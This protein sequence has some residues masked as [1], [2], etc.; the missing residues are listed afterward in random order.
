[1]TKTLPDL[2]SDLIS[3]ALNDLEC[4]ELDPRY[5]IRM[6]QWH[7]PDRAT[8]TCGVCFAG[9]VIAFS[10]DIPHT[11]THGPSRFNDMKI[12]NKL[13][14]LDAFRQGFVKLG[15]ITLGID[16]EAFTQRVI[17]PD[18]C[19]DAK[20]FKQAMRDLAATLKAAGL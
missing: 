12:E 19:V 10:L 11:Q 6:A 16:N 2:P 5:S 17:I 18:Y 4:A 15:L 3:L 7:C 13:H 9:S 20:A 8:K 1:M 14:A